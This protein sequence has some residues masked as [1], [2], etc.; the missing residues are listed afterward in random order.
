MFLFI[1]IILCA[2]ISCAISHFGLKNYEY[3]HEESMLA[4]KIINFAILI[5]IVTLLSVKYFM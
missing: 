2:C 1:C 4:A 3:D 5:T